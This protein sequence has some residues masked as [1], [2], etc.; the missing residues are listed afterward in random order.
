ME[1]NAPRQDD[2]L[3]YADPRALLIKLNEA[4]GLEFGTEDFSLFL[5]SLVRMQAP[6][7]IVELGTGLGISA[8]WMALAAQTNKS[9]HVWTVDNF[10]WFDRNRKRA[11]KIASKLREGDVVSLE[12]PTAE[13]FYSCI[14]QRFELGEYL[15]FVKGTIELEEAEHFDRYSFAGKP[16][17]LLFSDFKHGAVSVM[18][19]L[20]HFL[21]R[22]AP[23]SSMF[24]HSASTSWL[25][26]LLLEQACSHLNAGRV[27]KSIQD[28][29]TVDLQEVMRNRRIVLV[30]LTERKERKQNS[31]AW[32]KIEPVDVFPQPPA[33]MRK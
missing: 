22:M 32:L 3:Q 4:A 31:A 7:V 25:S 23:S 12:S 15:T 18:R 26:Y 21:P 28:F 14:S 27:P 5:Y 30:H 1:T 9:G 8:F 13:E 2:Y 16:I 6:Q 17:D 29:C 24:I 19:L 10:E 11:N 20:G 33:F